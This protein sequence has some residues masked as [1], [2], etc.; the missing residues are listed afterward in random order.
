V[1]ALRLV[2]LIE[3]HSDE[4]AAELVV[5]LENFVAHG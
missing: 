4:L 1:I 2:R 5:K 3:Q